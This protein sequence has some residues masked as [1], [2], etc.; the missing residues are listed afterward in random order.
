MD[1]LNGKMQEG[2]YNF[3]F[4][5]SII[6][7]SYTVTSYVVMRLLW[8]FVTLHSIVVLIQKLIN[9]KSLTTGERVLGYRREVFSE[10]H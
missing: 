4:Q 5:R 10:R 9:D 7:L 3:H 6:P 2:S 8:L 1:G